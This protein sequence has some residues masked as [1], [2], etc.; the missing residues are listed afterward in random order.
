MN[1]KP[2]GSNRPR[3]AG[4][5]HAPLLVAFDLDDTL[6]PSKSPLPPAISRLVARLLASVPVAIISGGGFEQFRIQIIEQLDVSGSLGFEELYLLPACGTQCYRHDGGEW[7]REYADNL[8]VDEKR[9]ATDA[10]TRSAKQLGYWSEQTWGPVIED[11]GSQVTFSALGQF[12][13]IR[14]KSQWDPD[15]EK[16]RRL[17]D[18]V[19]DLLPDLE[20]R[21]GGSTSIDIT[22]RGVD[23]AYGIL[24]L[25]RITGIALEQ[26]LY[27]GDR[28]EPGG[29]DYPVH[30]S[31]VSCHAVR[32][33]EET[34]DYLPGLIAALAE[35]E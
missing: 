12:A 7:K 14:P 18:T 21:V 8:P 10:L 28:L 15:G 35:H 2:D 6:A 11:R 23:K 26:M 25:S 13:P 5:G 4:Y 19:A 17:R 30:A 16:R 27:I 31:G 29:N 34:R 9:R 24:R 1:V 32:S 20:V 22:R 33:W 3:T